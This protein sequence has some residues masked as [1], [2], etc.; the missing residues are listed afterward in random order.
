MLKSSR[1]RIAAGL[2][3]LPALAVV[4]GVGVGVG[5]IRDIERKLPAP[6][7]PVA[8]ATSP[9]VLDR[10]D[11][12]L[13]PFTIADGRWRLPVEKADV[14]QRFFDMLIAYEDRRFLEHDG[15]DNRALVRAAGAGMAYPLPREAQV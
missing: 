3:A 12:L 13:R 15:V 5:V 14:D 7:E 10:S 1:F 4:A 2:I 11:R 8:V 9:V 6:P